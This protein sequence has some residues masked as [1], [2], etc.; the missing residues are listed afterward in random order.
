MEKTGSFSVLKRGPPSNISKITIQ[1]TIRNPAREQFR[2]NFFSAPVKFIIVTNNSPPARIFPNSRAD[3]ILEAPASIDHK[4]LNR[5]QRQKHKR[6]QNAGK[7]NHL[8]LRLWAHKI[9][10]LKRLPIIT[11][12]AR[13]LDAIKPRNGAKNAMKPIKYPRIKGD[14][15]SLFIWHLPLKIQTSC[16]HTRLL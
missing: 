14:C 8:I 9:S 5:A 16:F 6:I 3:P 7:P 13:P 11:R 10:T 2:A 4:E 12:G 1:I 15:S